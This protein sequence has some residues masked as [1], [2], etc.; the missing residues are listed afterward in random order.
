MFPKMKD[1][2]GEMGIQEITPDDCDP[3]GYSSRQN[4][5]K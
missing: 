1:I 5:V 2:K 3:F 4:N